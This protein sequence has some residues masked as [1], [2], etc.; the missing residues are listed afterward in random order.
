VT[1]PTNSINTNLQSHIRTWLKHIHTL[2]VEIGPRGP[3]TTGE[4]QGHLYCQQTLKELGYQTYWESFNSARSIF[5]PH[6]YASLA[7]LVAFAI[8]PLADRTSAVLAALIASLSFTSEL[9][10]L[11][12]INNLLRWLVP[13]AESQNV[14]SIQEPAQ[15]HYQDL[16][17]IGH[18]DTQRTPMI[19]KSTQWLA[20]YQ[21]F[22]TV[23][24]VAFA[25]M[26][27]LYILG[28]FTQSS[29]I[30]PLG[31]ISALCAILLA[32]ICI[33]AD[34]TPFTQGAND[35]A[36]AVGLVLTLAEHLHEQPLQHTRVWLVNTGCEEVQHYGAIDFFDKHLSQFKKP[37]ALIFEMLGCSGPAWLLNE[38]IIIPFKSSPQLVRLAEQVNAE[39]PELNGYPVRVKGGNTE[40][41]DALRRNI[42]ALTLF[43][44]TR[45][46]IAPYWH[47]AGDT[48]DKIDSQALERNYTFA[49]HFIQALDESAGKN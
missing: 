29:W 39:H 26:V 30:W 28:I 20:A 41:A 38:G 12:F 40:M 5:T 6:L 15:E 32:A 2:A 36:T 48:F 27:L 16:I 46:N 14:Y 8:Y 22:T 21:T 42:P 45:Q 49:W 37:H 34:L 43:G 9:M 31:A 11:A 18:V 3:T 13:K 7:M 47:Q 35:N 10:E 44:M 23:T 24:F 19:F 33:Q 17:L 1:T 4:R 25:G